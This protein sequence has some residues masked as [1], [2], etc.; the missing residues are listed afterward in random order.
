LTEHHFV[1]LALYLRGLGMGLLFIPLSTIS[2]LE[3]PRDKMAQASSITN[4]IRQLGGS[5]GVAILATLLTSRVNFHSQMFSQ[6]IDPHSQT[7]KNVT[8]VM[9]N[10]FEARAGSAPATASKQSQF[11]VVSQLNKEAYIQGI[12]DDFLIAAV[13]TLI[14]GLPVLWLHIKK[15]QVL[16]KI[17]KHEQTSI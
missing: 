8:A 5:L 1:M 13:I 7:Y 15:K 11:A 4:V 14:G 2:L 9:A 12:D 6:S 16:P 10:T 3:I 17:I